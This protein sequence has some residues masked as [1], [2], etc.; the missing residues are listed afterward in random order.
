LQNCTHGEHSDKSQPPQQQDS[1]KQNAAH[2]LQMAP[3]EQMQQQLSDLAVQ[4]KL[5]EAAAHLLLPAGHLPLP[6][7]QVPTYLY[8]LWLICH[9]DMIAAADKAL[10]MHKDTVGFFAHPQNFNDPDGAFE[11]CWH[12]AGSSHAI[13]QEGGGRLR[14]RQG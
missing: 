4:P 6:Q 13:R 10:R 9:T 8:H 5:P 2:Q 3:S 14:L 7:R 1:P 12:V 11:A